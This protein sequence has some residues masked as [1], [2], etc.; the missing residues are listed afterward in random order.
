MITTILFDSG[1]V[2]TKSVDPLLPEA[3]EL[4]FG[5]PQSR[6][7]ELQ[8]TLWPDMDLGRRTED[9]FW[10]CVFGACNIEDGIEHGRRIYR[11]LIDEIP[12]TKQLIERLKG[13]Y[14][15][16][17]VNNEVKEFDIA[18]DEIVKFF[19]YFDYRMSSWMLGIKKPDPEYFQEVLR[20]IGKQPDECLFIDDKQENIETAKTM[21]I[22][23]IQFI[24]A[25][26]LRKD[27][28]LFGIDI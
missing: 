8:A 24:N 20:Q 6:F 3:F 21:R 23:S 16:V 7:K 25:E 10:S 2:I 14:T 28:A 11:N 22:H 12:G 4:Q 19:H 13:R 5:I 18:R 17:L 15:L 1:G 27:C 26:Q 9:E